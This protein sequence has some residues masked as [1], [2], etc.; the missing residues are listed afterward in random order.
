MTHRI[1]WLSPQVGY[2]DQT[3]GPDGAIDRQVF[4]VIDGY[5]RPALPTLCVLLLAVNRDGAQPTRL[6]QKQVTCIG[7]ADAAGVFEHR[8]EYRGEF[9]RR[10]RDDLEHLA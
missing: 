8:L 3:L 2:M 7:L 5:Q 1:T 6:A 10:V 9:A 4:A